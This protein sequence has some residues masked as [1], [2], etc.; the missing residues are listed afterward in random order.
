MIKK[1]VAVTFIFILST[2]IQLISQIVVTRMFGAKV[3]LEI[4]LAAVTIPTIIVTVI[5]G[6]LNSVFL[7]LYGERKLKDPDK[8]TRYF[9]S[10]VLFLSI[11]SLLISFISGFFTPAISASLFGSRG[12]G[13][14]KNVSVQM[15]YLFYSMP[16]AVIA[17]L[18]GSYFYLNKQFVRF[19]V[20]QA[21]GSIV[22]LVI[23][24][25]L[26]PYIGTWALVIAFVVNIMAQIFF[27]IPPLKLSRILTFKPFNFINFRTFLTLFISWIPL[28][29]GDF[30]LRSD[31]LLI[32]SFGSK[33]TV[34]YLVYLNLISKIFSI[35]AGVMTIGI[36]ILLLPHLVEYFN[37]KKYDKAFSTVRKSKFIAIAVSVVVIL[38][39][40]VFLPITINILF[41]GNKFTKHDADLTI[42]LLPY[43]ILP[44]VGW[45]INGVFFQ[46]L[47]ALKKQLQI[48]VLNVFALIASFI[49]GSLLVSKAGALQALSISLIILLFT[50]IIGSEILWQ[51]EKKKLRKV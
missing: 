49:I 39:I 33:L 8:G 2:F 27:V 29:I 5:Y 35:A 46:P 28:I 23:I 50:G 7:P 40:I 1:G 17:T 19:P 18:F 25:L 42:S 31:M 34:G 38:M 47:I 24:I 30:A 22:N 14:V 36:Q 4:F 16:A 20:A 12:A 10:M 44:A 21:V 11:F 6:T 13:F 51:I 45:G 3:N 32:R 43:F 37:E 41:V 15:L 9:I 48:G 26:A